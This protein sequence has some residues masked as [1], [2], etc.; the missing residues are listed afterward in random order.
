LLTEA[1]P[2]DISYIQHLDKGGEIVSFYG[3]TNI[4][5]KYSPFSKDI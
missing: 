3:A 5:N 1:I 2:G 4:S